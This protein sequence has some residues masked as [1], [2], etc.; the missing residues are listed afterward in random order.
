M[1]LRRTDPRIENRY[2]H[3]HKFIV[4]LN[5]KLLENFPLF[6]IWRLCHHKNVKI[7]YP[8]VVQNGLQRNHAGAISAG[9]VDLFTAIAKFFFFASE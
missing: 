9:L 5:P 8:T 4:I 7:G 6:P 1:N 3:C 2:Q